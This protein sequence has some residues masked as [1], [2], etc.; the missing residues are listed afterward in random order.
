MTTINILIYTDHIYFSTIDA[1]GSLSLTTLKRLLETKSMGFPEFKVQVINRYDDF[2]K[3]GI[4]GQ[5][6]SLRKL[7]RELLEGFDEVWFFGWYQ[8]KVE[9][10]FHETYGSR[11]NEL[12]DNEVAELR[13]WMA[14]GGVLMTGDHSQYAPFGSEKDPRET[15]LC[16]GRALGHLVPRAGRLRKWKGPPTSFDDDS[17]N[18]VVRTGVS[19]E[20]Q[21]DAVPQSLRLTRSEPNIPPH[22]IFLGERRTIDIFPDHAHEGLVVM[23]QLDSNWPPF[24]AKDEDKKPKPEFVAYGCDKRSCQS[25]PVL[26]VYDGDQLGVGRIVADSTWHHYVNVN[27]DGFTDTRKDSP[28]DLLAQF[29]QNLA[30]YLSPLSKRQQMSRDLISW[31]VQHPEVKEERGNDPEI[32]GKVGLRHLLPITTRYEREELFQLTPTSRTEKGL[33]RLSFSSLASE[34]SLLPSQELV[35][36]SIINRY[37]RTAS[38]RL[39]PDAAKSLAISPTDD[40]IDAG[41]ADALDAHRKWLVTALAQLTDLDLKVVDENNP[42]SEH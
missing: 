24:H 21:G 40:L 26:V 35:V 27:L 14:W 7:T 18:T 6:K 38:D 11:D 41:L 19:G 34:R 13:R 15:F 37:F 33:Q 31:L 4:P 36:G 25:N 12:D 1:D 20:L 30:L 8:S 32:V 17:F 5:P 2:F 10:D 9:Q 22:P 42:A 23:P 16:L 3:P 39:N 29:F 28:L